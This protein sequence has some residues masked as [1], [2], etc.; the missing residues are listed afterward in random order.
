MLDKAGIDLRQPEDGGTTQ[1]GRAGAYTAMSQDQGTKLEGLMVSVQGHVANIDSTFENV[2][3]RMNAA[4]G[5]L[6]R[7]SENTGTTASHLSE[8]KTT[9]EKIVRDGVRMR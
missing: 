9:L 3:E 7:I 1:S 5:H 4:E 2:A 6:A 8:I